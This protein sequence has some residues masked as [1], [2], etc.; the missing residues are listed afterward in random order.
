MRT[1]DAHN[2]YHILYLLRPAVKLRSMTFG[3][4]ASERAAVA[5]R[6]FFWPT[7]RVGEQ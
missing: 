2:M 3:G 6:F 1:L 5:A 4:G 7:V